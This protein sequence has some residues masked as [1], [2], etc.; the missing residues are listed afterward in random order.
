MPALLVSDTSVLIDLERGS[1]LE[2]LFQLPFDV[3]VPDLMFEREIKT[4]IGPDLVAMGLR[5][6]GLEPEGLALA[7]DYRAREPRLSVT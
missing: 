5:V 7:Q 6:L 3:G 2:A 4:W 1:L